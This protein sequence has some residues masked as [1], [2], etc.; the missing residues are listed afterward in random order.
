MG[1]SHDIV[2]CMLYWIHLIVCERSILCCIVYFAL[3]MNF[4]DIQ[5]IWWPETNTTF[6]KYMKTLLYNLPTIHSILRYNGFVV[7]TIHNLCEW[8]KCIYV[9]KKSEKHGTYQIVWMPNAFGIRNT[10]Y[11]IELS[12]QKQPSVFNTTYTMCE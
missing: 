10:Q 9:F 5:T 2:S 1:N 8:K 3:Q 6:E 4:F 11:S 7:L 12:V